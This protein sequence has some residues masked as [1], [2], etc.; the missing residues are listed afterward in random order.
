MHEDNKKD[1]HHLIDLNVV[2]YLMKNVYLQNKIEFYM[3]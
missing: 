2:D 3:R 1:A